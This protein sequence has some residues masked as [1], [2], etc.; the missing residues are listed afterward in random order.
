MEYK[1]RLPILDTVVK[2]STINSLS[3]LTPQTFTSRVNLTYN[4]EEIPR[5]MTTPLYRASLA[6]V[7][8]ITQGHPL[9]TL[10]AQFS[11]D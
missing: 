11:S 5:Q 3:I 2:K 1:H 9:F 4:S 10:C 7:C 6:W 8:N